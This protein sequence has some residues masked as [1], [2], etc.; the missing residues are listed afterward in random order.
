MAVERI[1]QAIN[2]ITSDVQ[3]EV[4]REAYKAGKD[5]VALISQRV[6]QSGK[7]AQGGSFT[8]YSTKQVPA[9][10]YFNKSRTDTAEKK[11]RAKAKKKELLS[12]K[13]FREVNNLMATKK[14]FEFTGEM[15]RKFDVKGVSVNDN[16]VQVTI[17]GTSKASEDKI[18]LMSTL[19]NKSII[20]P[21]QAEKAIVGNYLK[22]WIS[23]IFQK[24]LQ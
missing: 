19:E 21:S 8:P 23:N 16:L 2:N 1:I 13:E 15:W 12:Y 18:E 14:N 7:T 6:I 11:V 9:F 17:G 5:F 4:E 10:Y 20:E 22:T 3:R 24:H